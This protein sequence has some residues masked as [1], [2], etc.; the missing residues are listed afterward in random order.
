MVTGSLP[1]P[2]EHGRPDS[3]PGGQR[4]VDVR[5]PLDGTVV[6]DTPRLCA[7]VRPGFTLR[8]VAATW[9][10]TVFEARG[11]ARKA[12]AC[13]PRDSLPGFAAALEEGALDDAIAAYLALSTRRRVLSAARQTTS[14][15]LYDRMGAPAKLL[16]PERDP[17]TGHQEPGEPGAKRTLARPGKRNRQEQQAPRKAGRSV[18]RTAA[19]AVAIAVVLAGGGVAA[20]MVTHKPSTGIPAPVTTP[21]TPAATPSTPAATPSTPAATPS[22]PA[23]RPSTPPSTPPTLT[24]PPDQTVEATGPDGATV[25][26]TDPASDAQDGTLT[27]NCSPA[28][29]LVFPLG[30]TTVNCSVTTA[31]PP[32]RP[33]R[34]P[35]RCRTRPR[36]R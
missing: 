6:P 12:Y 24:L 14:P 30:T 33:A 36:R 25:T 4:G 1:L 9:D 5:F 13:I 10:F 7:H 35:S 2:A 26:Y 28:S 23:A 15:G 3:A 11:P 22:T 29:G 31:A 17:Q 21:S 27:S 18:S 8:P 19:I 20:G 34:S 16:A 32:P